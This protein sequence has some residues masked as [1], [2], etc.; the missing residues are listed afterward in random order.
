MKKRALFLALCLFIAVPAR[1]FTLSNFDSPESMIVDSQDGAYY[2]SNVNGAP[3]AKDGNGYI[4]KI[5]SKGT[6]V[7]QKYIGGK[8]GQ[9]VLDAPKGMVILGKILFVT[10]IDSIKGFDK[11]TAKLIITIDLSK[12]GAK[13]LNDITADRT[14]V[15]YASDTLMNQIF[16][17]DSKK[18]YE[19]SVLK[20]SFEITGPNGLT[21][22]PKTKNLV[23]VAWQGGEIL[24]VTPEGKVHQLK[25]GLWALDGVDSDGHGNLY[26]SS[27]EKGEIYKIPYFG[28]GPI[29]V[30]LSGLTTPADISFDWKNS[31]LLIPSFKGNSVT[32]YYVKSISDAHPPKK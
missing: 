28:R 31:E 23:V 19:V 16:K 24:E 6:L 32:T 25:K 21:I 17:I 13:F 14:G 8:P 18:N 10:D 7:I 11:E 30:F 15:L 29:S 27:F 20:T 5:N 2:V 26:V 4:S 22:N 12:A 3:D 1:A 9:P